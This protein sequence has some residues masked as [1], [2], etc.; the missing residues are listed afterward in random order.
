MSENQGDRGEEAAL[1]PELARALHRLTPEQ[2]AHVSPQFKRQRFGPGATI[3]RQGDVPDR[4]YIL[5]RGRAEVWHEDLRGQN[6][7]I[8]VRQPGEYFGEI[9][10]LKSQ[11]RTASVI[12]ASEEG[13]ELLALE[14]AD[15]QDLITESRATEAHVARDMIRRLI[16]LADAQ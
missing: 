15:F 4:F 8:D 3:I 9:G 14:R 13:V 6:K 1:S 16:S 12:A 11:P 2:V 5:L 7:L 10:L